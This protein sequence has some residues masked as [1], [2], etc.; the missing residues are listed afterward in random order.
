MAISSGGLST[1]SRWVCFRIYYIICIKSSSFYQASIFN[2]PIIS[3]LDNIP[4][5][6]DKIWHMDLQVTSILICLQVSLLLNANDL[7]LENW[8][9]YNKW[10]KLLML[11]VIH[12]VHCF[13]R[14]LPCMCNPSNCTQQKEQYSTHFREWQFLG[15][16]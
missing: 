13:I 11:P 14:L 1:L 7:L 10:S 12:E 8:Y 16:L 9:E 2:A 3:L 5:A 6:S 15:D 4:I